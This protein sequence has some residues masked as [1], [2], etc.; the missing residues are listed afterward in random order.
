M[1][2]QWDELNQSEE[3]AALFLQ[4][5]G[6]RFIAPE[7]LDTER[8]SMRE[9]LLVPR[10]ERAIRRL[11]PWITDENVSRVVRSIATVQAASLMEAN[12]TLHTMLTYGVS[13][14]QDT[15]D[16]LGMK[17]R[18]V[19]LIDFNDP[20]N[21]ERNEFV[22]TRQ[23]SVQN[24]KNHTIIPDIVLFVNGVPLAV[25][26]CKSPKITEPMAEAI[27]QLHRYQETEDRFENLGA[28]KLFETVQIVEIGRAHV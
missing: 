22:F 24:V 9:V 14:T 28:P 25:I 27:K 18:T 8:A 17:S 5:L 11:N 16:G 6:W 23:F 15:G 19:N 2:D 3:P 20:L 13:V 1:T 7:T 4:K 12:E 26:E 21:P 10:L